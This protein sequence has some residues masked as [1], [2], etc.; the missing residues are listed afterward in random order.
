MSSTTRSHLIGSI[1][2]M[3]LEIPFLFVIASAGFLG[4]RSTLPPEQPSRLWE[5]FGWQTGRFG[6]KS[7]PTASTIQPGQGGWKPS[8]DGAAQPSIG[9]PYANLGALPAN[10]GS[11]GANALGTLPHSSSATM[12]PPLPR[13]VR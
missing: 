12:I 11:A 2:Q 10:G 6:P 8:S 13:Q 1:R 5:V 9:V 4:C 3:R 7:E